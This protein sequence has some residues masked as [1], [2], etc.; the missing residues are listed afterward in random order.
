MTAGRVGRVEELLQAK[1][2]SEALELVDAAL[3]EQPDDVAL[4]HARLLCLSDIGQFELAI[5]YG[6]GILE[7]RPGPRSHQGPAR[8]AGVRARRARAPRGSVRTAAVRDGDPR[9]AAAQHPAGDPPLPLPRPATGQEPVRP[10]ALLDAAVGPRAP[11]TIIEIGSKAGGGAL[12]LGDTLRTFD[13]DCHVHSFDVVPVTDVTAPNVTFHRGNGQNL[14][15]VIGDEMAASFERPLLVIEDADHTFET[16]IAVLRFFHRHTA[17]GDYV[18]VEDGNLSDVYPALYPNHS[19]GPH[20]A[21]RAFL[22]DHSEDYVIDAAYCDF[23]GYNAT[24]CSNGFLRR[25]R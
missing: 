20:R 22:D 19:S 10:G 24:T 2:P 6:K 23:F 3:R 8:G 21:I 1:R 17:P 18:V 25:L 7:A 4:R 13:I 15:A 11:G 9:V 12:W 5:E 16:T 14:E